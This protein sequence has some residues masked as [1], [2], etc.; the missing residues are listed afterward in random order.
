[1]AIPTEGSPSARPRNALR[2][3]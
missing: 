1:M 2:H 3:D